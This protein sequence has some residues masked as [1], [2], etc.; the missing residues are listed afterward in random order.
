MKQACDAAVREATRHRGRTYRGRRTG[1]LILPRLLAL[2]P[3]RKHGTQNAEEM[4]EMGRMRHE[5]WC[6]GVSPQRMKDIS[7]N[8]PE[9]TSWKQRNSM[10]TSPSWAPPRERGS[11]KRWNERRQEQQCEHDPESSAQA[12]DD[13]AHFATDVFD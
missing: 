10:R 11:R 1:S 7:L 3:L 2:A 4:V 9:Q 12:S 5:A 8:C 13:Q 6:A